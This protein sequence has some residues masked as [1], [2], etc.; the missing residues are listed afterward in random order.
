MHNNYW[1]RKSCVGYTRKINIWLLKMDQLEYMEVF[2]KFQVWVEIVL[3]GK[4]QSQLMCVVES[5]LYYR[6]LTDVVISYC[7]ILY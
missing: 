6:Y 2:I 5:E 1:A 7:I 4:C 3:E